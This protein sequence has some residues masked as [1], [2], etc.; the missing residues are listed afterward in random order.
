MS[1]QNPTPAPGAASSN[2]DMLQLAYPSTA[3]EIYAD[4]GLSQPSVEFRHPA[5]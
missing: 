5:V 3:V 2:V 4:S 1:G